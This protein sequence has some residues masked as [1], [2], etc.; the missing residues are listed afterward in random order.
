MEAFAVAVAASR[1][2]GGERLMAE[3]LAA[4]VALHFG[5]PAEGDAVLAAVVNAMA[6]RVVHVV[7][8][9]D[10]A[11]RRDADRARLIG[12]ILD[13]DVGLVVS[14]LD[15]AGRKVAYEADITCGRAEELGYDYLR[16]NLGRELDQLVQRGL[17]CA[18][19]SNVENDLV[20]YLITAQVDRSKLTLARVTAY[21]F[22]P[23][24][25][26]AGGCQRAGRA[27]G[28]FRIRERE[29]QPVS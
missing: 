28:C 27:P 13:L 7:S 20:E 16:D 2:A 29:G 1:R 21:G 6:G 23:A 22:F 14:E 4:T 12:R 26:K 25:P 3:R 19:V 8:K 5:L 15:M 9:T 10:E 17:D 18:F 24:V 11:A